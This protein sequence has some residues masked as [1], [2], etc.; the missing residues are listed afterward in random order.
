M[1]LD[2]KCEFAHADIVAMLAF[3][4]TKGEERI[5]EIKKGVYLLPRIWPSRFM[6]KILS[7]ERKK[8]E[9]LE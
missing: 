8:N 5:Q 1:R 9:I 6:F 4:A 2:A 3:R 7:Q